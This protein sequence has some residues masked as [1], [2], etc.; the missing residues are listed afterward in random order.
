M[1]CDEWTLLFAPIRRSMKNTLVSSL[2]M[3]RSE[4]PYVPRVLLLR[5]DSSQWWMERPKWQP[6]AFQYVCSFLYSHLVNLTSQPCHFPI[7]SLQWTFQPRQRKVLSRFCFLCSSGRPCCFDLKTSIHRK[8]WWFPQS[9]VHWSDFLV[10][11]W[12]PPV[13]G[14]ST[15]RQGIK[16]IAWHI[17]LYV[18]PYLIVHNT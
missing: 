4:A 13:L 6:L 2:P 10:W 8:Q 11:G 15:R 3:R 12:E 7:Q 16:H 9:L 1:Q 5:L 18:C 14:D 17:T